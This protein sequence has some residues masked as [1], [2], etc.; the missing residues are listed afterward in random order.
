MRQI[1]LALYKAVTRSV[2]AYVC[3]SWKHVAGV[4]VLKLQ[5]LQNRVIH[6]SSLT[7]D[8]QTP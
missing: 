2:M 3:P 5:L 6:A 8:A 4:N 1:K 7:E